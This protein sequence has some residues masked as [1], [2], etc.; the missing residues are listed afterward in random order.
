MEWLSEEYDRFNCLE[1][2]PGQLG[3]VAGVRG[4]AIAE[5]F[6][7]PLRGGGGGVDKRLGSRQG[8]V[9][10]GL[11]GTSCPFGVVG[12]DIR[13]FGDGLC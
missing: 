2:S 3:A 9:K 13:L 10:G 7:R 5:E 11:V 8:E 1:S 6:K 4:D 12:G